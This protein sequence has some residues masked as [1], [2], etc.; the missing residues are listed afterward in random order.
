[1]ALIAGA[2]FRKIAIEER[3]LAGQFGAAYARYRDE[4]PAL[5][6]MPWRGG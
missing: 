4:V 1:V 6:P 3:F 2:L 5:V